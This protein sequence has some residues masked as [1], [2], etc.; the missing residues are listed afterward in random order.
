MIPEERREIDLY[1]MKRAC[2]LA[3]KA[4]EQ[5]EVPV[6]SVLID[7]NNQCLAEG[8]NQS[9]AKND[10]TAHAEIEALRK[11][12]TLTKNYR[13]P[14]STLYV[15]LE[16]CPM[17]AGAMVHARVERV[18]IGTPDLRTGAAGSVFELL[19]S[20][21]LNHSVLV[22]SGVMQERCSNELKT[23]FRNKRKAIR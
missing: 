8:W 6:G 2:E 21:H 3:A 5:G 1:W 15:T 9:I 12:A 23:F 4:A 16:P 10:P 19:N 11:A 18:V 22:S 14:K 13:L 20:P 7:A 17:C